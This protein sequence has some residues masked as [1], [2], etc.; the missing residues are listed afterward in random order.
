MTAGALKQRLNIIQEDQIVAQY[1][2]VRVFV[3]G[4]VGLD[5]GR[6]SEVRLAVIF[7]RLDA[8]VH[9]GDPRLPDVE[10]PETL[11][12][13][14]WIYDT[15]D[16]PIIPS[17]GTAAEARVRYF[18]AAP[19]LPPEFQDV[20][21]N[22][23]LTQADIEGSKFW[24]VRARGRDRVFV[25]GGAGTSFDGHPLPTHQYQLGRPLRLGAYNLG[26]I[27]GDHYLQATVGYLRGIGRLP[28]F[29]GGPIM[30]GGWLENGSAFNDWDTVDWR[31]NVGLGLVGDTLFGPV[32][33]GASIVVD[34]GEW[35]YY[36]GVGRV[37]R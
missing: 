20:G 1:D 19:D 6:D 37:F 27:R 8:G 36:V 12:R 31:T 14:R 32:I 15:Q 16:S 22:Q 5:V 26:E 4:D 30:A 17:G 11:A 35:R 2:Q 29:L 10:G 3:A 34:D 33:L 7:G 28:D 13:F 23:D 18:F 9:A 25:I 24:S 21:S